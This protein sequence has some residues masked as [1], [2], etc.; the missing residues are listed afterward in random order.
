[1]K[2]EILLAGAVVAASVIPSQ[3]MA[4]QSKNGGKPN[5]LFI[6]VDDWGAN[7]LSFAGSK[8]Y[9]TPNVDA[10]C[11]SG[12]YFNNGYVAYPR[13]VPSRYSLMTGVH[14]AR[15]QG[16]AKREFDER[17]VAKDSYCIAEPFK[18]SGYQTFFI[19]KWHLATD[20]SM[21]QDKG[22]DI[23]IGGGH[24]GATK[25]YFYPFD[26]VKSSKG[27][28]GKERPIE[29]MDDAAPNEYLTDYMG[30]KVVDYIDAKHDKPFFAVCSFYAVH[31]PLQSKEEETNYFE[32][33]RE[34]LGLN[35]KSYIKE[36]AGQTKVEQNHPV[37][38]GMISSVD[39]AVGDMIA[40]LKRSG[41]YD[42]TIII[43]IS[44]NGG[45]SSRGNNREVATSNSPLRAGKGH[46]YE[47]GIRVPFVVHL[48]GQSKGVVSELPV[49]G[50]DIFP[51]LVDLCSLDVRSDYRF[52]G[53]SIRPELDGK[54][55]SIA[56]RSL[57]WHKVDERPS[58]TGDYVGSAIRSGDYKLVDFYLQNRVELYDL[59]KDPSESRNIASENPKIVEQMN[60]D[61]NAWR[62][63]LNVK[64][65]AH[66]TQMHNG[67]KDKEKDKT[68]A[69]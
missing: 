10:L 52:D 56:S 4:A 14:C 3:F 1:M 65:A 61:L 31:T 43:L 19:G 53:M 44:D 25:S 21:P 66:D 64:M 20:D 6:I 62:K 18:A 57:Y 7:D 67:K 37:Y 47:G 22:F 11:K 38:A 36:E 12:T 51:T 27:G 5:V 8:F 13:S 45:L 39:K 55:H 15:P 17:K 41:A 46:L 30:R 28:S 24:A 33:K 42:N 58:S 32:A 2:K 49:S 35:D 40:A 59:K 34:K 9:E 54:K 69:K 16:L 29:G 23:N 26:Q 60:S 68:K 48:P 50:L 63:E